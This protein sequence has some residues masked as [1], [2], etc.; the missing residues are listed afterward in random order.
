MIQFKCFTFLLDKTFHGHFHQKVSTSRSVYGIS[1]IIQRHL[2][3]L[4]INLTV[5]T[6]NALGSNEVMDP[7]KTLEDYGFN[8]ALENETLPEIILFYDFQYPLL[9][10]PIISA[11]F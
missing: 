7:Y 9:D 2:G 5:S 8:G 10:C 1:R 6:G 11:I 3:A 4:T